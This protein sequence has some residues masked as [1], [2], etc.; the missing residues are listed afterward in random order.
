MAAEATAVDVMAQIE[1]LE[2]VALD[3]LRAVKDAA[4][5][6][7]YRIKYLGANGELKAAMKW[8]GQVAKEQKPAVGQRLN[9]MKEAVTA[10]FEAR[11]TEIAAG[12]GGAPGKDA[13]DVTEPGRRPQ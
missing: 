2:R 8:L 6:E 7:Q 1:Q 11:K 12:G 10:A 5:L 13:V 4:A 3:E 9:G